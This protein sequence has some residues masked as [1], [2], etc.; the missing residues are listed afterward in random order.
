MRKSM[1]ER[2]LLYPTEQQFE[3]GSVHI[4][5]YQPVTTGEIPVLIESKTAHNPLDYITEILGLIQADVFD[6]IRIDIRKT[7]IFYFK[8]GENYYKANY[9][10]K[11]EYQ[12]EPIPEF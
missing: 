10:E 4:T 8:N 6:R 9:L 12:I 1:F 5:V 11:G 7:G 3:P 2:D